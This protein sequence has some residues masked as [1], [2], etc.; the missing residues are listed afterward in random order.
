[1]HSIPIFLGSY[2]SMLDDNF[3]GHGDGI[4]SA[5]LNNVTGEILLKNSLFVSNPSYLA[6]TSDGEY[7]Y[8]INELPAEAAPNIMGFKIDHAQGL[9]RISE[10]P[11]SGD[12]PCHIALI[13]QSLLV[14]AY[15]S[16]GVMMHPLGAKGTISPCLHKFEHQGHSIDA[17]RQTSPHPHQSIHIKSKRLIFV[18]DLGIDRV[19]AYSLQK[20]DMSAT[21]ALDLPLPKGFGPRHMVASH[22]ENYLFVI[23]ELTSVVTT[24]FWH[25]EQYKQSG[26]MPLFKPNEGMVL[27]GS[28]IRIHPQKNLLFVG[29]RGTDSIHVFQFSADEIELMSIE[30]CKGKTLRDFNISPNGKWLIAAFQDSDTV[31][32][33]HIEHDGSLTKKA[34]FAGMVSPACVA[35]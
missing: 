32:S 24:F 6:V 26:Q 16:G 13:E 17:V 2:T 29:N 10:Q 12:Y 8:C 1:M 23:N 15:G 25:G 14:S 18:P 20:N 9:S 31:Q 33:F 35:F 27:S 28:A 3:G 5:Q 21:E 30:Y 34:D 4:Y 11:I 19:K 7:L 22:C